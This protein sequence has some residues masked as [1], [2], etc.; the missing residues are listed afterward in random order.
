MPIIHIPRELVDFARLFREAGHEAWFVGGAIR[1]ELLGRE[2][3]DFDVATDARPEAVMGLFRKVIPTGIKHGT[4]TVLW[5]GWSVETTTFRA[6]GGYSDGRH[7]DEVRFGV[8]IEEDLARRDFT[9]NAMAWD[10]LS[11]RLADPF[12]GKVDLDARLIRAVGQATERFDEDGLRILRAIRFASQ[13][14]F[15]IE[16]ATLGALAE[17]RDRLASVSA[18]RIRDEFSKM[19]LSR[20]PSVALRLMEEGGILG[21]VLP[22][23]AAARGVE[24]KGLHRFDVLDH[25]YLATDAVEGRLP[26]RLAALFHD[27]GKPGTKAIDADG[28]VIFHR[29]EEL[30]ATMTEAIM[31]R[32]RYP[33]DLTD[34]VRHLVRQHMFHYEDNWSDAAVRRFLARVGEGSMEE[35]LSLRIADGSAMSGHP[36]DP[37]SLDPL[38]RRLGKIIEAQEALAIKDLAVKGEDLAAIGVPR[39]PIMGKM[40][41]ELLEAV[42]ED[43]SLNSKERLGDIATRIKGKYGLSEGH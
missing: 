39:G 22:E 14:D 12:G 24:Q 40:L 35:L 38:R 33:N 6:E 10:P 27:L 31:R 18:E 9:I 37:R 13:L 2:A 5:K 26:L 20:R 41:N 25:L 17:R 11:S 7:P 21:L 16:A 42:I 32:L 23:L 8:G 29:H 19:L 28:E 36:V 15:S 30:S 4:V 1:D 3:S 34:K 43:P